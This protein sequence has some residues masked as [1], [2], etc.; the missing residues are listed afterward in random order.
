M[1]ITGGPGAPNIADVASDQSLA[2]SHGVF[3]RL[4]VTA[5]LDGTR[6][7]KSA[8]E[9]GSDLE[10]GVRAQL[11]L[12]LPIAAPSSDWTVG[13]E[14]ID[15][16]EQ[17]QHL[18]ELQNLFSAYPNLRALVGSDYRIKPDVTVAREFPGSRLLHAVVSCKWTIRSDRVQNV[19]HEFKLLVGARRGRAPHLVGV[20]AEP[21]PSRLQSLVGGTGEVDAVYHLAFEEMAEAVAEVGNPRQQQHWAEMTGQRRLKDWND[22]LGDISRG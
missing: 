16:F 8:Q 5:G 14:S 22:L 21:L 20:T 11:S 1:A 19:R 12:E 4:G 13:V 2:I 15:L 3:K 7:G 17:Y 18:N 10:Q 9:L 6:K